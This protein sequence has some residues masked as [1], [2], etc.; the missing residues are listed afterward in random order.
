MIKK[1]KMSTT[2][3]IEINKENSNFI[4]DFFSKNESPHFKYYINRDINNINDILKNHR[5]TFLLKIDKDIVGYGHID[6]EK[7]NWLGLFVKEEYRGLG[8]GKKILEIIFNKAKQ[9]EIEELYLSVYKSNT[10]AINLYNKFGFEK[11]EEKGESIFMKINTG[12]ITI[13]SSYGE[14][15]DKLTILDIKL[16]KIL[17]ERRNEVQKEYDIVYKKIKNFL[18]DKLNIKYYYNILKDVNQTIW[19]NQDIFRDTTD[20]LKK[21]ELC[22]D[23]IKDND[24]RFLVKN[25]I[26]NMLNSILKEQKGYTRR[27]AIFNGHK[28]LGD[29]ITCTGIVRYYSTIYDEIYVVSKPNNVDILKNLYFDDKS[30]K[31]IEN[32]EIFMKQS[33]PFTTI[34]LK[35]EKYDLIPCGMFSTSC[36]NIGVPLMFY[37]QLGLDSSI[38]WKYSFI[39]DS[40]NSIELYQT[41]LDAGIKD[42]V[43]YHGTTSYGRLFNV[44]DIEK[45]SNINRD[46]M[47]FIDVDEN[48]YPSDHKFYKIA[49]QFVM[50]YPSF[51]KDTIKNASY[52]Y[53]SD[54]YLF[55]LSLFIPLNT[56]NFYMTSRK[57]YP[58]DYSYLLE[59]NSINTFTYINF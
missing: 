40:K 35:G 31:I 4:V 15:F 16:N 28:G 39:P 49:Q 57:Q 10:N 46:D 21:V 13:S 30:I 26:N 32:E 41:I 12:I 33:E 14:V 44:S 5:Y 53:V 3:I 47:L 56:K 24:R 20:N 18:E 11:V 1:N 17:D 2:D 9:L 55:C 36:Q 8:H 38:L 52:V 54:S 23:I 43:I 27:K 48:I 45:H 59:K 34:E 6:Y 42:Y 19:D 58:C 29:Y 50:R 25:K 51:Y 37:D 22:I 7:K